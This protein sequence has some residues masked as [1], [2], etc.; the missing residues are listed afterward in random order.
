MEQAS[1]RNDTSASWGLP[2]Y[3]AMLGFHFRLFSDTSNTR[4]EPRRATRWKQRVERS[5]RCAIKT[6]PTL[7]TRLYSFYSGRLAPTAAPWVAL[8]LPSLPSPL[9]A[10]PSP[11]SFSSPAPSCLP[12]FSSPLPLPVLA[13]T[14][15]PA[16]PFAAAV[17]AVPGFSFVVIPRVALAPCSRVSFP[18]CLR[19]L[20]VFFFLV[21]RLIDYTFTT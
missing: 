1:R 2:R 8:L 15:N 12:L 20:P 11:R 7:A 17:P 9:H 18:R 14:P 21:N 10:P 13:L 16:L 19:V 3:H 4:P 6:V 5:G